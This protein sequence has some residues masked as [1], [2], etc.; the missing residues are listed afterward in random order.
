MAVHDQATN[1]DTQEALAPQSIGSNTTTNGS[2]QAT[3]DYQAV[4]FVA[5]LGN[6]TDGDFEFKLQEADDDGTGSPDASTWSDVSNDDIINGDN[7]QS[8]STTGKVK[9]GY[10][11]VKPHVRLVVTSTNVTTGAVVAALAILGMARE[12][13]FDYVAVT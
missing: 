2:A 3:G 8:I 6:Y 9:F 1:L 11:G 10:R 4:T 13:T 12:G 5:L 7:T